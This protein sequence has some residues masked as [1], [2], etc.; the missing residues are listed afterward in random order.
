MKK[1]FV[2]RT[3]QKFPL[4]FGIVLGLDITY[5]RENLS[6]LRSRSLLHAAPGRGWVL[7]DSGEKL[8]KELSLHS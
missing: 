8:V 1:M 6:Q 4:V 3:C 2:S 7:T 5:A